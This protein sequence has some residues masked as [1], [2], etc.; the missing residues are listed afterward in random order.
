L[1]ARG[2]LGFELIAELRQN[3][4]FE[5]SKIVT[6]NRFTGRNRDFGSVRNRQNATPYGTEPLPIIGVV[7]AHDRNRQRGQE[8]GVA[9]Q[10]AEAATFILG[11]YRNNVLLVDDDRCGSG[12]Q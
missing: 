8:V 1:G 12:D 6:H 11:T 7:P 5:P 9:V 3:L 10:N 4:L 2:S